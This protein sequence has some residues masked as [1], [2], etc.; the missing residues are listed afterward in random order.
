M[1]A[2][3]AV[4]HREAEPRS[5][6]DLFR[7]E[8][9]V[10]NPFLR[11][12][13]H[14]RPGI[15]HGD[16]HVRSRAELYVARGQVLI[17]DDGAHL[18]IEHAARLLI[19]LAERVRCIC[20]QIHKH[21]LEL[22]GIAQYGRRLA[23]IEAQVRLRRQRRT[24][25]I[26][27]LLDVIGDRHRFFVVDILLPAERHELIHEPLG[28]LHPPVCPA[29]IFLL[30]RFFRQS[31]TRQMHVGTHRMQNIVKIVSDAPCQRAHHLHLLHLSKLRLETF[32]LA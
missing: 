24:N 4:H 19:D 10:E 15:P 21:L 16:A 2:H 22:I 14:A 8:E 32:A 31:I 26:E 3:D 18:N 20:E 13:V 11:L 23:Q 6:S 5:F 30:G 27:R 28:P 17:H 9:R 7:G 12:A 25:Q 29:K 1:I